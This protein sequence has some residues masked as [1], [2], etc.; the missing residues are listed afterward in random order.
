[1][2]VP[3]DCDP[4]PRLDSKSVIRDSPIR[5]IA[6][7]APPQKRSNPSR[8]GA[9]ARAG[10]GAGDVTAKQAG[11]TGRMGGAADEAVIEAEN[12]HFGASW[13]FSSSSGC[14]VFHAFRPN[15]TGG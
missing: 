15:A 8:R 7:S 2:S 3:L 13:S 1:M 11:E 12:R 4:R 14:Q 5:P 9:F 6:A 10:F